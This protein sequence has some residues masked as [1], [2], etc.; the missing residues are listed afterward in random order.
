M[1]AQKVPSPGSPDHTE[2]AGISAMG[3][4]AQTFNARAG[5]WGLA[6]SGF[7]GFLLGLGHADW[8]WAAEHAQVLAG[9]VSYPPWSPVAM[10]H[11]KLWSLVPQVGALLLS[12][13][14]SELALSEILSGVIG[15][16]SFQGLALVVYALSR[17]SVLAVGAVFVIFV[18]GA[19]DYGP[20]YRVLLLGGPHTYGRIGLAFVILTIGLLGTGW[21]RTGAFLLGLTPAM[22]VAHGIW[23]IVIVGLAALPADRD[24]RPAILTGLKFFGAGAIVSVVSFAAHK[25]MTPAIVGIDAATATRYLHAF[26]PF[27]DSHR[28]PVDLRAPGV[29]LNAFASALAVVWL[30]RFRRSL[31]S[32]VKLLLRFVAIGGLL[33]FGLAWWTTLPAAWMPDWLLVL[34]PGRMLNV[35]VIL[36][37]ALLLGLTSMLRP[38]ILAE[39]MTLAIAAGLLVSRQSKLWLLTQHG[40]L[41]LDNLF[42]F[43]LTVGISSAL[44]AALLLPASASARPVSDRMPSGRAPAVVRMVLVAVLGITVGVA[45][46]DAKDAA[47]NALTDWRS[48]PLLQA[49][50][51][52]DGPLLTGAD[53]WLVQ[54]R[55][56]RPVLLDGGTLDTLPYALESGPTTE[57]ILHDVYGVDLFQPPEEARYIGSVPRNANRAVWEARSRE[58]WQRIGH[59]YGVSQVLTPGGWKLDLPIIAQSGYKL[60]MVPY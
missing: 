8:Q 24:M 36:A 52:G 57:R 60:Y 3:P 43:V 31:S 37:P 1:E 13:G 29:M 39:T 5:R 55:T 16:L 6:L 47:K 26:V 45:A 11:A 10:V 32:N 54:L 12:L 59:E 18:S 35:N 25:A 33:S 15:L 56:R 14:V 40:S 50:A 44:C 34:M 19:T 28:R 41:N 2:R 51:R 7:S 27:W 58:E 53:L 21:Y 38:A 48:D 22:H 23:V 46:L 17:N 49:A 20:L 30:V 4:E 42:L 9:I